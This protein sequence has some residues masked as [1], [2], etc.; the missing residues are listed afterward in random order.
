MYLDVGSEGVFAFFNPTHAGSG[1]TAVVI[2]PPFGWDLMCPYRARRDWAEHLAARGYPTMRID[3][4]GTGDSAGMPTDPARLDAWT[5]AVFAAALSLRCASGAQ[6]IVAIGIG[7]G[8]MVA[9]HAAAAGAAVEDLVLWGVPARGRALVREL[10]A[11]ARLSSSSVARS[12]GGDAAPLPHGAV[13]AAGYLLSAETTAALEQ[14]DLGELALPDAATR[15]MLLLGRGQAHVD[16]PLRRSLQDAGARVTVARGPGLGRIG[17]TFA[18]VDRWL[19]EGHDPPKRMPRR[20]R[21]R[22]RPT[23][24]SAPADPDPSQQHLRLTCEEGDLRESAIWIERPRGRLFGVLAEPVGP[25]QDLCMVLLN[26]G[27]QRHIGP[28]RMWV[29]IARRWAVRG[30]PSLRIDLSGIGDSDGDASVLAIPGALYAPEYLDETIATLAWLH[31]RGLPD[32]FV[33]VGLCSGAY[34]AMHVA[35]RDHRIGAIVML[36]PRR[37]IWDKRRARA[38]RMRHQLRRLPRASALR[39]ALTG[40]G[41]RAGY[42]EPAG[43]PVEPSEPAAP[44]SPL[45]RIATLRLGRR[46]KRNAE[47]LNRLFDAL[48]DHDQHALLMLTSWEPLHQ[49]LVS[50]GAF[51]GAGRWPNLELVT[52]ETAVETHTL[53]PLWLQQEIHQLVDRVLED[54]LERVPEGA[55]LTARASQ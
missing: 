40:D 45:S 16:E 1:E 33:L 7:L 10:R 52:F 46:R 50:S 38:E 36:N 39:S 21:V 22:S 47:L 6:R 17:E 13:L 9:Y 35:V 15:R 49:Q 2:C 3:L 32:R 41:A 28:N 23:D 12:G 29:E 54:E 51:D 5:R 43:E 55:G 11:L 37:L 14:L 26:A 4:Q 27:P 8:G 20:L 42:V 19:D 25:P 44:T 34:W 48:R 53:A 24:P 18:C 30:V 31:E